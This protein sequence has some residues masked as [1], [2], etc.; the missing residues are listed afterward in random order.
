MSIRGFNIFSVVNSHRLQIYLAIVAIIIIIS[1]RGSKQRNNFLL[2]SVIVRK[3][4]KGEGG[5]REI[6]ASL[7]LTWMASDSPLEV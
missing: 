5:G 2:F 3:S 6:K 1:S 7:T 4:G